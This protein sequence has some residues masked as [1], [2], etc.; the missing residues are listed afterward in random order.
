[1]A[2]KYP[3]DGVQQEPIYDTNA[4]FIEVSENEY[5]AIAMK[6]FEK[7]ERRKVTSKYYTRVTYHSV[8]TGLAILKAYYMPS[9]K[10]YFYRRMGI[11]ND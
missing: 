2:M 1:M 5:K 11:F 9:G 7:A 8:M 6:W 4:E 10:K 3:Y